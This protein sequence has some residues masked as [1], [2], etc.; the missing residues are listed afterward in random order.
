MN[1]ND[2]SKRVSDYIDGELGEQAHSLVKRH[3]SDCPS[4]AKVLK[5]LQDLTQQLSQLPQMQP[6]A[7]FD[8]AL[9]SRLL[10]EMTKEEHLGRKVQ[11]L[12]FPTIPRAFM[13][14]AAIVL[15]ALGITL[16]WRQQSEW[17]RKQAP[18][19]AQSNPAATDQ[20]ALKTL[21][22]EES[23]TIS[24]K[25]YRG[26]GDSL[27]PAAKQPVRSARQ[28]PPVRRVMVRF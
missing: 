23:Y 5:D 7:G 27:Q 15:L 4:C 26:Q 12:L 24:S 11:H 22:H 14:A 8:F 18:E 1:C 20:G 2:F 17:V 9:R 13:S 16:G 3:A 19:I 6:T 10:L 28:V 25:F 21:S